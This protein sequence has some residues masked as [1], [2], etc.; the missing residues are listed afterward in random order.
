[1]AAGVLGRLVVA[2]LRAFVMLGNLLADL[3]C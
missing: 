1:V 2:V 3:G